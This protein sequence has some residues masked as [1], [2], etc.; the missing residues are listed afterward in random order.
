MSPFIVA[1]VSKVWSGRDKDH[2][3]L[4]G[5]DLISGR[6][7]LVIQTNFD[8]GY[9]LHDWRLSSV[10]TGPDEVTETIVAIF[11][12]RKPFKTMKPRTDDVPDGANF[13]QGNRT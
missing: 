8:R 5:S 6:F 12:A 13:F 3:T 7:A 11:R 10:A 4:R 9:D 2:S 1:E